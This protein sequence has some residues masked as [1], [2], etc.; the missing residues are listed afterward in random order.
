MLFAAAEA[1]QAAPIQVGINEIVEHPSLY[2][3]RQGFID[4][5]SE[6][7]YKE[8]TDIVYDIQSA[9]GD[10]ATAQTIARKFQSDGVDLILAI[11]TPTAQAAAHIIKDIPI[12][13]TAV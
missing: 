11:A 3:A 4:S 5:L 12:L 2:Q 9:Q 10:L 7:G 8:G 6:L 13:I 1:V